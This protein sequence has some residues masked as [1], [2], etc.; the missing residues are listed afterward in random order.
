MEFNDREP[1]YLQII[2]DFKRKFINGTYKPGEEIP[3]RRELA[4]DLGVNPNTVQRAYREMEDMNLIKTLRGQG[5]YMTE[6]VNVLKSI[7][8]EMVSHMVLKF[9]EDMKALGKSDEDILN[10]MKKYL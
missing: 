4:K 6:D 10:Y 2:E 9:I 8:E 7:Q 5:S 3:S 1:I